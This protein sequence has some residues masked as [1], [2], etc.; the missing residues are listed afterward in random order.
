[1][2]VLRTM[3]RIGLWAIRLGIAGWVWQRLMGRRAPRPG[4]PVA[5]RRVG[6]N[7]GD[8]PLPPPTWDARR[9]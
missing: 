1:M 9:G 7:F 3:F 5:P 8:V 4:G 6:S 2:A